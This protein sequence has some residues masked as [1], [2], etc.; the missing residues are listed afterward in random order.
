MAKGDKYKSLTK[1]LLDSEKDVVTLTFEEL[2]L[3]TG[4]L[5]SS[6]YIYPA[7]WSDGSGHSLSYGWLRAGYSVKGDLNE[8]IV[9]FTK[10]SDKS[11]APDDLEFEMKYEENKSDWM[12][13][14]KEMALKLL[15]YMDKR[16]ELFE[17]MQFN[18]L[19][20]RNKLKFRINDDDIDPFSVF[21]LVNRDVLDEIKID[22]LTKYAEVLDIKS[23]IPT[24]FD[25]IPLVNNMGT[26]FF[27]PKDKRGERD[28][29]NLWE[30][31]RLALVYAENQS[32]EN[33]EKFNK[34]FDIVKKQKSIGISKITMGLFW[35]NPDVYLN[36]DRTNI[37]YLYN[38]EIF[39]KEFISSLYQEDKISK[40]HG[41]DYLKIIDVIKDFINSEECPFDSFVELSFKSYQQPKKVTEQRVKS[42]WMPFLSELV[43]KLL[44]YAEDREE[45]VNIIKENNI[46]FINKEITD[47]D[48]FTVLA[49]LN[50][51]AGRNK[52]LYALY[53]EVFEI[54]SK[55]PT[56]FTG[57][58]LVTKPHFFTLNDTKGENDINNLWKLLISALSYLDNKDDESKEEFSNIFDIVV[59]QKE[60][61][62]YNLSKGLYWVNP[63][64]F[65]CLDTRTVTY[66]NESGEVPIN[67]YELSTIKDKKGLKGNDYLNIIR[68]LKSFILTEES[69]FKD[70]VELY[71]LAYG[72]YANISN[73]K[74]VN[75]EISLEEE[76]NMEL[77]IGYNKVYYGLPGCG[78]SYKIDREVLKNVLESNKIRV[79]FHQDYSY[80][81]FIG[82]IM[83]K[84]DENNKLS[85]AFQAGPFIKAIQKALNVNENIYLIIEEINRGNA[86]A[87]F[88][89]TFQLL[90]RDDTGNSEYPINHDE[91]IKYINSP[92]MSDK[93]YIPSN[94]IILAS[95]NTSDQNVFTLDTAFK[96]RW[97]FEEVTN[98]YND[99]THPYQNGV[100]VPRTN[101]TWPNFYELINKLII[102]R[103]GPNLTFEDKRIGAFFIK[104]D[105][106]SSTENDQD[107]QLAQKFA[108]KILEYLW[109]DV[110]KFDKTRLF[111]A[112]YKTLSQ[113]INAFLTLNNP[114]DIFRLDNE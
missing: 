12:P 38:P 10:V 83:P 48:P 88:G 105:T 50:M 54:Q 57:T 43:N 113:V 16:D 39:S 27:H 35:I 2:E 89:D 114:M 78:K 112:E 94:L 74:K 45:L 87:I 56:N 96:R 81:D 13:F 60:V 72:Y 101:I 52:K 63:Y 53:K 14:Y 5:P 4:G 110:C 69:P 95:M 41:S 64:E 104:E 47:I 99:D 108:H 91:A 111:K 100:Y 49:P 93:L 62:S 75:E 84:I 71:H 109:N 51:S 6:V 55:V 7:A 67:L 34:Y 107:A 30:F 44:D 58:A 25:G 97:H 90:D 77:I 17:K 80:S 79:T 106:L 37:N 66:I 92:V 85:Y 22:V 3:I 20:E 23:D 8:R 103:S 36:L 98:N 32:E 76:T 65:V 42:N 29:D 82:Q 31:F 15:G 73:I 46:P 28:I 24:S 102:D 40:I 9:V 61:G 26:L 18:H 1:Y 19:L 21:A 33:R 86:P 68:E 59:K 11:I 70:F